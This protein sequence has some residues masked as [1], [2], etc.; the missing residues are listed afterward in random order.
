MKK[1]ILLTFMLLILGVS[2]LSAQAGTP[3]YSWGP[4]YHYHPFMRDS[5]SAADSDFVTYTPAHL[6]IYRGFFVTQK[7]GTIAT[8]RFCTLGSETTALDSTV[9]TATAIGNPTVFVS[10]KSYPRIVLS[11]GTRYRLQY[12]PAAANG[13]QIRQQG[14]IITSDQ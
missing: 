5:S 1:S 6:E 9:T 8:Y 2:L 3:S 10:Q 7:S 4:G 12:I 11:P 14:A 13:P